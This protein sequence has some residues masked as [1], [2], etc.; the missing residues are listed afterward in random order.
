MAQGTRLYQQ[1]RSPLI[2]GRSKLRRP[3]W[4]D[5]LACVAVTVAG[6]VAY[7]L[8][9]TAV[10]SDVPNT[11]VWSQAQ[12]AALLGLEVGAVLGGAVVWLARGMG[13][14]RPWLIGAVAAMVASVVV[15][16]LW[17]AVR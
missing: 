17:P 16:A 10:L 11:V 14:S 9:A 15:W 4:R 7:R 1:P 12:A 3:F 2:Q 6:F 13:W 8:V 5:W